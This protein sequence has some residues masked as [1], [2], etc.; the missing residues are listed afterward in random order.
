[1]NQKKKNNNNTVAVALPIPQ[2]YHCGWFHSHTFVV[3]VR[4]VYAMVLTTLHSNCPL[5]INHPFLVVMP[6]LF[7]NLFSPILKHS[8][9]HP[10]RD[11]HTSSSA[12]LMVKSFYWLQYLFLFNMTKPTKSHSITITLWLCKITFKRKIIYFCGP[13]FHSNVKLPEVI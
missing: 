1:M 5:I 10:H 8:W 9:N 13:F 3:I 7:L 6:P 12:C 2:A 11:H 4:V